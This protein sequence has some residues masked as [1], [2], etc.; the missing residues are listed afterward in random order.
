[1]QENGK[2]QTAE[3]ATELLYGG[4]CVVAMSDGT[5]VEIRKVTLRTL[6]L[7]VSYLQSVMDSLVV[8]DSNGAITGVADMKNPS[9]V[10]HLISQHLDPSYD[11]LVALTSLDKERLLDLPLDDVLVV[12]QRLWGVNVDFFVKKV[13]PLLD[14]AKHAVS[15]SQEKAAESGS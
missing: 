15:G 4:N 3:E 6:P 1:M 5:N 14:T 7:L 9:S 2:V 12:A 11:V 13:A 10:L 8:V